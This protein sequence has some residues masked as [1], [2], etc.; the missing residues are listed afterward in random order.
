M[1][2]ETPPVVDS[3][4]SRILEYCVFAFPVMLGFTF[5]L[6]GL[7]YAGGSSASGG[8]AGGLE[9]IV[10]ATVA[11]SVL[12]GFVGILI[13]IVMAVALYK[14]AKLVSGADVDWSPSPVL[15][16]V[17]GFFLSGLVGLHYLYERY[18][19]LSMPATGNKWWYGVAASFAFAGIGLGVSLSLLPPLAML[20][21]SGLATL[22]LPVAIYK[23]AA[24]VRSNGDGWTPNPVNYFLASLVL[25]PLLVAPPLVGGYYLFQRN[26]HVG[27]A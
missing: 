6:V 4:W 12:F 25:A 17:G 10:G 27:L 23:D 7:I 1:T 16:A 14:D 21:A 3:R 20:F 22:V 2:T 19:R 26:R 24:Y 9:L 11:A 18:N 5:G 13:S 8:T 15:Y